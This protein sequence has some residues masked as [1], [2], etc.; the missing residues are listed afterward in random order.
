M[1]KLKDLPEGTLLISGDG[2]KGLY[3][4][5]N[6]PIFIMELGDKKA[7]VLWQGTSRYDAFMHPLTKKGNLEKNVDYV[8]PEDIGMYLPTLSTTLEVGS[9]MPTDIDAF[10]SNIC[11]KVTDG[12]SK[13]TTDK[14][15]VKM[16][17]SGYLNVDISGEPD[18]YWQDGIK[19][20]DNRIAFEASKK[21]SPWIRTLF[22][23]K[24]YNSI[25]E[26]INQD[27]SWDEYLPL[28]DSDNPMFEK[29][30]GTAEPNN[31]ADKYYVKMEDSGYLN[32]DTSG[33]SGNYW[34]D[35]V[36]LSDN[37]TAFEASKMDTPEVHISFTPS[38]Y[39]SIA[40]EINQD[41]SW[42][43][44]LPLFDSDNPMFEKAK[45]ATEPNKEKYDSKSVTLDEPTFKVHV[46]NQYSRYLN[47][48][49]AGVE[50]TWFNSIILDDGRT[51]FA[52]DENPYPNVQ[53]NFT[54]SEYK[55][56]YNKV[57]ST[58]TNGEEPFYLPEYDSSNTDAFE[59]VH[60]E[61]LPEDKDSEKLPNKKPNK[62]PKFMVQVEPDGNFLNEELSG[63]APLRLRGTVGAVDGDQAYLL[64]GNV[65]FFDDASNDDVFKTHFTLEEYNDL[66][67]QV[68][69]LEGLER[70]SWSLPE[71]SPDNDSFILVEGGHLPGYVKEFNKRIPKLPQWVKD[72]FDNLTEH[73]DDPTVLTKEINTLVQFLGEKDWGYNLYK[74]VR[75]MQVA[76][77]NQPYNK[78]K[79]A[80]ASKLIV[81]AAKKYY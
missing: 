36:K 80:A 41:G 59:L 64:N 60:G 76:L 7:K 27:G 26:E 79:A 12:T 5:D 54:L 48:Q 61:S 15:Y 17:D 11:S 46:G 32:V 56:I 52:S 81:K 34:G 18:G 31:E 58:D 20:S 70:L 25:A 16:D 21:D 55:D 2:R 28:F 77:K 1:T 43:E 30:K 50:D 6:A 3:S 49:S 67:E 53:V 68:S 13:G 69:F 35:S 22:T 74:K 37:R 44:Y 72:I 47:V 71:Y 38:E 63:D 62:E 78:K 10:C 42:D 29:A 45:N 40:E 14:Y 9:F 8:L 24:E 33:K 23:P 66:R 73:A 19:L 65:L 75:Q 39:N 51:V 57:N 4:N